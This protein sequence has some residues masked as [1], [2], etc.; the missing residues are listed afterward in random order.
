MIMNLTPGQKVKIKIFKRRPGHW[1]SG[2]SMDCY[3]GKTVEIANISTSGRF[4][5]VEDGGRW[6]WESIDVESLN[7]NNPNILFGLRKNKT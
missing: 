7:S 2:G 1:N 6:L 3:M 5:I 4:H